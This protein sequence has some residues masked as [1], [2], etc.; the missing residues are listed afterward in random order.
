MIHASTH[1]S[2]SQGFTLVELML[3]M[4]FVAMLL[5]VIAGVVIQMSSIYNKGLTMKS[6]NQASRSIIT[7]MKRTIAESSS[8][9][10]DSSYKASQGRLCTG[11]YTYIWNIGGS[12][13]NTY[14]GTDADKTIRLIK[15]RDLGGTY[16]SGTASGTIEFADATEL[17]SSSDL[18]VQK[19]TIAALTNNTGFGKTLYSLNLQISNADQAAIITT[20][21]GASCIPPSTDATYQDYCAVN[22]LDFTA[23]AGSGGE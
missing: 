18:A 6:V 20:V 7:D 9:S 11:A 16:C 4:A 19:F 8:F 17:L 14:S 5:L 23:Q 1:Q 21:D 22:D 2:R 15:V 12:R 3:A 13:T 10:L